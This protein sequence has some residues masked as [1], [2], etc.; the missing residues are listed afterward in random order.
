MSLKHIKLSY[1]RA[2][3]LYSFSR[4]NEEWEG[5]EDVD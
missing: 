3:L 5:I 4:W 1:A 2:S